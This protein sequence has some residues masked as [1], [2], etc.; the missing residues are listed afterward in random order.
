VLVAA[1]GLAF[2]LPGIIS[3][4][5]ASD[6][7]TAAVPQAAQ[8]QAVAS[9]PAPAAP[10]PPAPAV[11]IAMP[12]QAD[13]NA[14]SSPPLRPASVQPEAPATDSAAPDDRPAPVAGAKYRVVRGDMLSD[15]AFR[16]YGDASKFRQIQAANPGI[17]N[18][19]RILVD[20]MIF[21]PPDSRGAR[22]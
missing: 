6:S 1:A 4:N 10:H 21:I 8:P 14:S 9:S 7:Q 16:V 11:D 2:F 15:I 13:R 5:K 12:A 18:K 19:D 3:G 17:R 22:R 20:Q